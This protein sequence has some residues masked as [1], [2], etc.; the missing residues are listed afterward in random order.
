M[1]IATLTDFIIVHAWLCQ[2]HVM[3]NN[4]IY[5]LKMWWVALYIFGKLGEKEMCCPKEHAKILFGMLYL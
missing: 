5:V 4:I 3:E 1:K 2:S